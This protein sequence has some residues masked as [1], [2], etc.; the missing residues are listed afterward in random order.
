MNRIAADLPL[1]GFTVVDLT[2]VLAG[3]YCTMMLADLGARVIKIENPEGGDDSRHVGPFID[4]ESAYF[5]SV[6]RNKESIALDL[7][8]PRDRE[9]L[10][11]M[12]AGADVLV[13]NFRAGVMEKLGLTWEALHTANPRLVYASI[14][15]FGQTGPYRDRPAYDMVV[16]AMGGLMS[17]TGETG[18]APVRVGVSIGDLGAGLYAAIGIQ[19]ALLKRSRTGLGERVDIGMLDCQVALLENAIARHSATGAVPAPLG[20]RHPSI[21]PFDMFKTADGFIVIAAGNDTLFQKLCA[22]LG[23]PELAADRGFATVVARNQ[24]HAELKTCMEARLADA[25]S[26]TWSATLERAGVPHGPLQSVADIVQ[27]PHVRARGMLLQASIGEDRPITLA[28]NPIK[29]GNQSGAGGF[30]RS[31]RLDE[32]RD[33]LLEEFGQHASVG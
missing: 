29:I 32:H 33:R 31:P 13:E 14:S 11:A 23:Q 30:K 22:A 24:H 27:D 4:G 2:R 25:D 17:V 26:A 21:T 1:A 28:G 15:G 19:S 12:I 3:P 20:T 7:K 16:Q 10:A 18:G 6:N 9:V 8:S 5:A